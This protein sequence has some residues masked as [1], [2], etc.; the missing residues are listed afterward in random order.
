VRLGPLVL[1]LLVSVLAQHGYT[2]VFFKKTGIVNR[3]FIYYSLLLLVPHFY[4]TGLPALLSG[5]RA[6]NRHSR[7][8]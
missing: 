8:V 4:F 3:S 1:Q 2:Q 7:C 5:T 6:E